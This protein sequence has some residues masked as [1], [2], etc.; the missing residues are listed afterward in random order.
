MKSFYILF[1]AL[2]LALSCCGLQS[3]AANLHKILKTHNEL[4][5]DLKFEEFKESP[6]EG[7]VFIA[8]IF[9]FPIVL[10]NFF[11]RLRAKR[12]QIPLTEIK[13]L[14][15]RYGMDFVL[16]DLFC[17]CCLIIYII[18][19]N[20]YR[21]GCVIFYLLST[22]IFSIFVGIRNPVKNSV[23]L[24]LLPKLLPILKTSFPMIILSALSL[25]FTIRIVYFIDAKKDVQNGTAI[26]RKVFVEDLIG[27]SGHYRA[28]ISYFDG[29]KKVYESLEPC[30][31][32]TKGT[33]IYVVLSLN[34]GMSFHY[35]DYPTKA[36]YDTIGDFAFVDN[37][38]YY[39]YHDYAIKNIDYVFNSVGINVV[40]KAVKTNYDKTNETA[41][42]LVQD[43]SDHIVSIMYKTKTPIL[44]TM[45]V[46]KNINPN[47]S[48]GFV[49][50]SNHIQTPENRAKISDYGYIFHYDVYSKQEIESQC[51]RIKDYVEQ[52]KKRITP[53]TN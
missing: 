13:L 5:T 27:S 46:F 11:R 36:N 29:K 12:K 40:F 43:A 25:V 16:Y 44:D 45:L 14:K 47:F 37:H 48:K 23:S 35:I 32:D 10:I 22:I 31:S 21:L 53:P 4:Q 19:P 38:Q 26:I 49:V 34:Y 30:L 7:F 1:F 3:D 39:S 52:Y 20:E 28:K 9:D 41:T 2:S 51:P 6:D 17:L 8:L 50:C 18:I 15:M 24:K 33:S 42:L